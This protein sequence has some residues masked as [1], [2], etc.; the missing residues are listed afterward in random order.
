[1]SAL[2]GFWGLVMDKFLAN[3]SVVLLS[4]LLLAHRTRFQNTKMADTLNSRL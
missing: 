1:M 3:E 2:N 4:D